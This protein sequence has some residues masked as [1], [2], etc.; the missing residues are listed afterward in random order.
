MPVD[1]PRVQLAQMDWRVFCRCVCRQG[2]EDSV[3]NV[4][5]CYFG[6]DDEYDYNEPPVANPAR[7]P[8]LH[9]ELLDEIDT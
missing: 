5:Q 3:T 9:P 1:P 4:A 8:V 2:G 6:K 7:C